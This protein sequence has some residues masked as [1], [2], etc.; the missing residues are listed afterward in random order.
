MIRSACVLSVVVLTLAHANGVTFAQ[1]RT[2]PKE[3]D[4]VR[5]RGRALAEFK[6]DRVQVVAAYYYSQ[7][8]HDS[9]WLLIEIGAFGREPMRIER[10][11]IELVTPGGRVVPLSSQARWAAASD[12]NTLLLQRAAPTRHQVGWY[13]LAPLRRTR[14]RFFARP[15][16][17]GTVVNS[18]DLGLHE[19]VI[20]DLLFESPTG[21]WDKGVHALVFRCGVTEAVLPIELR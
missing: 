19:L 16:G 20:G 17:V 1:S 14:L 3:F 11:G 9:N 6:D 7:Q 12:R 21:L 18:I 15:P 5:T 4:H 10:E 13:F 2:V 8:H